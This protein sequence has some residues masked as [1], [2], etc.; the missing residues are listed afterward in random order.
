MN[1]FYTT[2]VL[3]LISLTACKKNKKVTQPIDINFEKN[4]I[5]HAKPNSFWQ[6]VSTQ[7]GDTLTSSHA[8]VYKLT[9]DSLINGNAYKVLA[10]IDQHHNV[11][12]VYI[13]RFVL[14]TIYEPRLFDGDNTRI[15]EV[16]VADL[17]RNLFESWE[18]ETSTVFKQTLMIDSIDFSFKEHQNVFRVSSQNY[19]QGEIISYGEI[20]YNA[21]TGLLYRKM[22]DAVKNTELIFELEDYEI[23]YN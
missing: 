14:N 4:F 23:I 9:K 18:V 7:D 22:T 19:W 17:N 15:L 1:N 12:P 16:P 8:K 11:V 2:L 5:E 10:L 20:Y 3:I 21:K 6:Y 13:F